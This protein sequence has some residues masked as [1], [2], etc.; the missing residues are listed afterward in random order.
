MHLPHLLLGDR[1]V[2]TPDAKQ[3]GT[4]GKRSVPEIGVLQRQPVRNYL[5]RHRFVHLG[6]D[7]LDGD[8]GIGDVA[9]VR[10]RPLLLYC[11]GEGLDHGPRIDTAIG[12]R[13]ESPHFLLQ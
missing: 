5:F 6:H 8:L 12:I 11:G 1:Q 2:R 7:R 13:E 10:Q 4:N 3:V 9:L